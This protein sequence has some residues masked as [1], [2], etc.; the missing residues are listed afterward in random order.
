[1][2]FL[3]AAA[4]V[5]PARAQGDPYNCSCV[6]F[7]QAKLAAE[8]YT[9]PGGVPTAGD[10]QESWLSG[11]GWHRVVPPGNGTIPSG[12]KPMIVVFD[13]DQKGA[14]S[15]GHMALVTSDP[16]YNYTTQKWVVTVQQDDWNHICVQGPNPASYTFTGIMDGGNWGD[17][18]GINFYVPN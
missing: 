8:G 10:Y 17:L 12:G 13:P 18:Y 6:K 11:Q 1:M 2:V 5:Q 4:A 3:T 16:W 7:V 15:A 9:L 14:Y